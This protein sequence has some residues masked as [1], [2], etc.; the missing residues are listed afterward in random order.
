MDDKL[1][2][3][4]PVLHTRNAALLQES[5][6]LSEKDNIQAL[7]E[8]FPRLMHECDHI[9]DA[10]FVGEVMSTLRSFV[11]QN[12][13]SVVPCSDNLIAMQLSSEAT[14]PERCAERFWLTIYLHLM[15]C[16]SLLASAAFYDLKTKVCLV[17]VAY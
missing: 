1:Y 2:D 17:F 3:L 13:R 12:V 14:D 9:N 16:I 6:A 5:Q 4:V 7:V 10:T 11:Q 15:C 8:A